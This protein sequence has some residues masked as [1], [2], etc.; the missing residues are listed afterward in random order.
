[1]HQYSVEIKL[2]KG[3]KQ[4]LE[5]QPKLIPLFIA[6]FLIGF[7]PA[8]FQF[9]LLGIEVDTETISIITFICSAISP[10][11]MFAL[12][13][14]IVVF[15]IKKHRFD[16]TKVRGVLTLNIPEDLF[17]FNSQYGE[18][19]AFRASQFLTGKSIRKY[20]INSDY[21]NEYVL[22]NESVKVNFAGDIQNC[23]IAVYCRNDEFKVILQRLGYRPTRTIHVSNG[24]YSD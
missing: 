5:M 2:A 6:I 19:M 1:M 4:K 12:I 17:I 9:Q 21:D 18:T 10:I 7:I 23:G 15:V 20:Y 11:G 24:T 14:Y 8:L 3:K 22:I 16:R 13:T